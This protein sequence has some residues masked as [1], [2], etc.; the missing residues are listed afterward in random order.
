METTTPQFKNAVVAAL[1]EMNN[2]TL[3][4]RD[5]EPGDGDVVARAVLNGLSSGSRLPP[6]LVLQRHHMHLLVS[7][8]RLA[9]IGSAGSLVNCSALEYMR[10]I[11]DPGGMDNERIGERMGILRLF[12]HAYLASPHAMDDFLAN[13]I[14]AANARFVLTKAVR[15]VRDGEVSVQSSMECDYS[16]IPGNCALVVHATIMHAA[17]IVDLAQMVRDY[18]MPNAVGAQ[19]VLAEALF[20]SA[21]DASATGDKQ[22]ARTGKGQGGLTL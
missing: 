1:N 3:D 10:V 5:I 4:L 11:F 17:K 19:D 2:D 12:A 14:D 9:T 22:A 6:A 21:L 13:L 8:R 16:Q 20:A 7:V 18:I 15:D